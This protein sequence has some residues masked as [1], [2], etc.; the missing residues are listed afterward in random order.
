[1][2]NGS[3]IIEYVELDVPHS[4]HV[5]SSKAEADK[6][7]GSVYFQN[8]RASPSGHFLQDISFE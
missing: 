7:L 1:M 4:I 6:V 3:F 8:H 5:C 2:K